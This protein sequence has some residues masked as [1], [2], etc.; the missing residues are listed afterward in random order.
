MAGEHVGE[1][2]CISII[3]PEYLPVLMWISIDLCLFSE[4][5]DISK[6]PQSSGLSIYSSYALKYH[7]DVSIYNVVSVA[8]TANFLFR[9]LR[10]YIGT[11]RINKT[12]SKLSTSTRHYTRFGRT[13][14]L[15]WCNEPFCT[16]A[17]H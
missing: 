15:L 13:K 7:V 6:G 17:H 12:T 16:S 14:I 9:F 11:L 2:I 4:G 5:V 8:K 10:G 1:E 3:D